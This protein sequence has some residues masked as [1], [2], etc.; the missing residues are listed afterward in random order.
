MEWTDKEN[1][2]AVIAFHKC[3]IEKAHISELLKLLN[4][5]R[6]FVYCTVKLF[7]DMGGVSDHKRSGRP[8]VVPT[9]H[10]INAVRSRINQNPVRKQNIMA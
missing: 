1:H 7:F 8:H 6:V 2:I 10:V 9:P 5:M 3:G 4:I